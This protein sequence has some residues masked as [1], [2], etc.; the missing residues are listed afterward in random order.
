MDKSYISSSVCNLIG[1][2]RV[3]AFTAVAF[4]LLIYRAERRSIGSG[5]KTWLQP[6][7]ESITVGILISLLFAVSMLIE[8]AIHVLE[9]FIYVPSE[10]DY[11]Y[12]VH[13]SSDR[14]SVQITRSA[15]KALEELKARESVPKLEKR[16]TQSSV[17]TTVIEAIGKIL[18]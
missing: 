3:S 10:I 5:V 8:E 2:E 12:I 1:P 7:S 13:N 6:E 17:L 18:S 4:P 9:N 11:D 14:D 15:I 16:L